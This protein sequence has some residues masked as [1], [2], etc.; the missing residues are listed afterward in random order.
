MMTVH[1]IDDSTPDRLL[2]PRFFGRGY[3]PSLKTADGYRGVA[4]SFPA[5][6]L[7]PRA[8]WQA[9]IE[10]R[11]ALKAQLSDLCDQANLPCLNQEQTNY[12]WCNGPTY[13]SEVVRAIQGQWVVPLSPASV[14]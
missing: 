3:D 8:E 11:V 9:R 12:C 4:D 6:M 14:G 5:S 7:I 1:I 13:C 2:F 10:E